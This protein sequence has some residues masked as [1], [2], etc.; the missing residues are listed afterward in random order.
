MPAARMWYTSIKHIASITACNSYFLHGRNNILALY[1]K[2]NSAWNWQKS[3]AISR[4]FY[5]KN[6]HAYISQR[7]SPSSTTWCLHMPSRGEKKYFCI[8]TAKSR[9]SCPKD[10]FWME[11]AT[12]HEFARAFYAKRSE[13]DDRTVNLYSFDMRAGRILHY[14]DNFVVSLW[15]WGACLRICKHST[16]SE[17]I[18][19]S[20]FSSSAWE[21]QE[22][23]KDKGDGMDCWSY[24]F[25][26]LQR[27]NA[28]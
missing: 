11:H 1:R 24:P 13:V 7:L 15:Q 18:R 6:L 17:S 10:D 25:G 19:C 9:I 2:Q 14:F 26:S 20:Q 16:S 8:W 28:A 3:I 5:W 21:P 12:F 4:S 22:A 27:K 23:S